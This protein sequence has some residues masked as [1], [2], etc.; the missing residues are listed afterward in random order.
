MCFSS[1]LGSLS[2]SD[3]RLYG[4]FN[5]YMLR[6]RLIPP[7]SPFH[8]PAGLIFNTLPGFAS[9]PSHKISLSVLLDF[10]RPCR[11][12]PSTHCFSGNPTGVYFGKQTRLFSASFP[13]SI[14]LVD[15]T[16]TLSAQ[17]EKHCHI[18]LP[19]PCCDSC[20]IILSCA[21]LSCDSS[22]AAAIAV[23]LTC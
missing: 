15:F 19:P 14:N 11:P 22:L 20:S 17:L 4:C 2:F 7:S 21:S 16:W 5:L 18:F 12:F 9:R 10:S 3:R 6:L 23:S 1:A 13:F 8:A